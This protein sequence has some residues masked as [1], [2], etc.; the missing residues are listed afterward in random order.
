MPVHLRMPA[1][2]SLRAFGISDAGKG[3]YSLTTAVRTAERPPAISLEVASDPYPTS[4]ARGG[5]P[6]VGS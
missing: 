1:R 6:S 2:Y 4:A 5:S 3:Q